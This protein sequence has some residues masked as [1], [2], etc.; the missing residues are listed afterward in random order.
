MNRMT[1]RSRSEAGFTLIELITVIGI[2]GVLAGISL[3]TFGVYRENAFYA[4][5][6]EILR[7]ARTALDVGRANEENFPARI[8]FTQSFTGGRVTG[9]DAALIA[10]GLTN[11]N[12]SYVYVYHNPTCTTGWCLTDYI[13]SR[14]CKS[15]E[16]TYYY[17]YANGFDS[18]MDHISALGA[19]WQCP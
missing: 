16:Y 13:T 11:N 10:P 7:N 17:R 15:E 14:N 9:A 19:D 12:R 5:S 1:Q 4:A 3:Q 18:T 8:L 2:L 6:E